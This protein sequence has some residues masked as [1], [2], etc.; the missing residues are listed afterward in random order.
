MQHKISF[1]DFAH[2]S[3]LFL[4]SNNRILALKRAT[5]QKKLSKLI[6]SNIS[7]QD[8]N[9]IIF[10]FSRYELSDCKKR[11]LVK[12]LNFSLPPNYLDYANCL[13]DFELL[14]RNNRNLD[15]L[16]NKGLDFVKQE[17]TKNSSLHIQAIITMYGIIF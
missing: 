3:S 5:K 12:G 7:V 10:N 13:F 11:L 2:I 6:K 9:K 4:R 15:I 1:I 14:H 8:R 17:Q 16:A